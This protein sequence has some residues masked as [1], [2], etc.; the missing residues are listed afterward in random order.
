MAPSS[1]KD[2]AVRVGVGMRCL[3]CGMDIAVRLDDARHG[4]CLFVGDAE[5]PSLVPDVEL[6]PGVGLLGRW[7]VLRLQGQ[8]ALL[9][10]PDVSQPVAAVT[11]AHLGPLHGPVDALDVALVLP[12]LFGCG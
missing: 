4:R 5:P 8:A 11:L 9:T 12:D 10:E 7:L 6:A 3:L 2:L 1:A